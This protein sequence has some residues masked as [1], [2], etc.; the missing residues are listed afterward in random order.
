ML[1]PVPGASWNH[2]PNILLWDVVLLVDTPKAFTGNETNLM[3]RL[4]YGTV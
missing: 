2:L 3:S 4:C 1:S